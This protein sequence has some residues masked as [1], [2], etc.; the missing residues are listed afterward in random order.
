LQQLA[1]A[2]EVMFE[3]HI[4]NSNKDKTRK[5]LFKKTWLMQSEVKRQE[6]EINDELLRPPHQ[7]Q[8]KSMLLGAEEGEQVLKPHFNTLLV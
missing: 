7:V 4:E 3:E 1:K 2:G 8:R 6:R 5:E